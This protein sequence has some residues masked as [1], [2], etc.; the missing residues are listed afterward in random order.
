MVKKII[1]GGQ[2]GADRAALE[3]AIELGIPHGGW[4]PKGGRTEDGRLPE[5]YHLKET[6]SIDYSQ[7]TELN[8]L[9]SDGTL[10]ISHGKLTGGSALTVKLAKKHRKPCL[11]I[12]LDEMAEFKAVEI[13]G[14]WIELR[15][16]ST[17]NVAGPRASEDPQIYEAVTR[18]L[19]GLLYPPPEQIV[20]RF[21]KTVDEA[22]SR[23]N[24]ELPLKDKSMIARMDENDLPRLFLTLGAYI[25]D[26]FGLG[27]GNEALLD[28]CRSVSGE[29][30]IHED[31]ASMV[32]IRE[33]WEELRKSHTIKAVK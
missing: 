33:L 2:T 22:V 5:R 6:L 14:S 15:G 27:S 9:D 8:I 18:I 17:L 28:S 31:D 30:N 25:R 19:K 29:N 23:L 32:I 16:I 10:I 1:S 3:V 4:I 26:K 12:D 13:I 24:S 21:P 11:H 20:P 7:R